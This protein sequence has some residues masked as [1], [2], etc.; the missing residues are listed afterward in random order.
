MTGDSAPIAAAVFAFL[1]LVQ[2]SQD[3]S[4]RWDATELDHALRDGTG[5]GVR[6]S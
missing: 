2:G 6:R 4:A 1:V 3:G 5:T